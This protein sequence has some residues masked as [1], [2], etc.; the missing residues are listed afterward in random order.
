MLRGLLRVRRNVL[1]DDEMAY[2]R[3]DRAWEPTTGIQPLFLDRLAQSLRIGR[4][5]IRIALA[6]G[7]TQF[8]ELASPL[9][10]SVIALMLIVRCTSL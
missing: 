3:F 4:D 1:L 10:R 5:D 6:L 2:W 7:S 8:I 9:D